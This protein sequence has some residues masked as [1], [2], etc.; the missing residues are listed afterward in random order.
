MWTE[1][2]LQNYNVEY[3]KCKTLKQLL[4][5][6]EVESFELL[7]YFSYTICVT[8]FFKFHWHILALCPLV[9]FLVQQMSS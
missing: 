5:I 2:H 4:T 8:L 1:L 9:T 3:I 6:Q 7:S